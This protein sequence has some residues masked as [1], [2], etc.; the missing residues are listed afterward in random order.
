MGI[1]I[2][3]NGLKAN[4]PRRMGKAN[5]LSPEI[6]NKAVADELV[7]VTLNRK[8]IN[9]LKQLLKIEASELGG[10]PAT[11]FIAR[12]YLTILKSI[13]SQS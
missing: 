13:S 9:D 5:V 12:K 8:Q 2:R 1:T 10:R 3:G 11:D 4:T 6:K 7:T